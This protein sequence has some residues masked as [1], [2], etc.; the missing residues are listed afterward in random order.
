MTG[1]MINSIVRSSI[2]VRVKIARR[3]MMRIMGS[4]VSRIRIVGRRKKPEDDPRRVDDSRLVDLWIVREDK[5][6]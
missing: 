5:C 1:T 4:V 2:R 6:S 3:I